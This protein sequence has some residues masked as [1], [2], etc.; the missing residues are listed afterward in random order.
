MEEEAGVIDIIQN[1][2]DINPKIKPRKQRQR[3][4]SEDRVLAAKVEVQK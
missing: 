2:F 3:K 4:M 1:S